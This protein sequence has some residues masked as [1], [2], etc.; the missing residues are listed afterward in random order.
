MCSPSSLWANSSAHGLR[1]LEYIRM[2]LC[3]PSN[4]ANESMIRA[5]KYLDAQEESASRFDNHEP[6]KQSAT[7]YDV[8]DSHRIEATST[9]TTS[10]LSSYLLTNDSSSVYSAQ[11]SNSPNPGIF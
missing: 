5:K 11:A 3:Y 2:F 1:A 8:Y 4:T 10:G 9:C 6:L 7:D